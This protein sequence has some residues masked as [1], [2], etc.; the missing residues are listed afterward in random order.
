MEA[1]ALKC[2]AQADKPKASMTPSS[3]AFTPPASFPARIHPVPSQ[4][5]TALLSSSSPRPILII[6]PLLVSAMLTVSAPA[7]T[8]QPPL[9]SLSAELDALGDVSAL[10]Q[11]YTV[12]PSPNEQSQSNEERQLEAIAQLDVV[13]NALQRQQRHR[14]T[15][16]VDEH[17]QQPNESADSDND[18]QTFLTQLASHT[19]TRSQQSQQRVG[20]E[21]KEAFY[22]S[23]A[24]PQPVAVEDDL[25]DD[26]AHYAEAA[27]A[28]QDVYELGD[29]EGFR[30][31]STE[32]QRVADIDAL[33]ASLAD[34][35]RAGKKRR[36][37]H[38]R[39]SANTHRGQSSSKHAGGAKSGL[40]AVAK[41]NRG[42]QQ[43]HSSGGATIATSQH[44]A[45]R[46]RH[47]S[48]QRCP[49][50]LPSISRALHS[51]S[52]RWRCPHIV[53]LSSSAALVG[54]S[55]CGTVRFGVVLRCRRR[56]AG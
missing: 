12:A 26:G 20:E 41:P 25:D 4:S 36:F 10:L 2:T 3:I 34:E 22:S 21:H 39:Y 13:L 8:R 46:C 53:R 38:V 5:I 32:A 27:V 28:Q 45:A 9:P 24:S 15:Q 56:A 19:P 43:R 16:H 6:S 7:T 37:V 23:D 54:R 31:S 30:L 44:T 47:R 33:L 11:R 35:E 55:A 42:A 18:D 40:P 48:C 14:H 29:G 51:S 17:Q 52:A 1:A 49:Y 50:P